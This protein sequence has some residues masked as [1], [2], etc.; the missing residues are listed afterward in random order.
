LCTQFAICSS[1]R[2]LARRAGRWRVHPIFRSSFHTWQSAYVTPNNFRIT[3]P[4]RGQ[5]HRSVAY[6]WARGPR[7]SSSCSSLSCS[8][9]SRERRP[10]GPWQRRA[11][12][13]PSRQRR[14]H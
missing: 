5:V 10:R 12:M 13:P 14:F 9:D 6:P 4:T 8:S 3:A 1:S 11:S 7:R 2:S